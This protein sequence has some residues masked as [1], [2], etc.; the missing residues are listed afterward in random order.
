MNP[1]GSH[2]LSPQ[3]QSA[4]RRTKAPKLLSLR[5]I[6]NNRLGIGRIT[7]QTRAV[8]TIF[9]SWSGATRPLRIPSRSPSSA[10]SSPILLRYRKRST[11]DLAGSTIETS[12]PSM[13]C[14]LTPPATMRPLNRTK[15]TGDI[16]RWVSVRCGQRQHG[17]R[18]ASGESIRETEARMLGRKLP[19]VRGPMLPQGCVGS[20]GTRRKFGIGFAP[21][22][23]Q[24]GPE[25]AGQ[26]SQARRRRCKDRAC[27]PVRSDKRDTERCRA[28]QSVQV[29]F[30]LPEQKGA[31]VMSQPRGG[32]YCI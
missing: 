14:R 21:R 25:R 7:D 24:S 16:R 13:R 28:V 18:R 31:E 11:T 32:A 29:I 10:M 12:I 23:R 20:S 6:G 9:Q 15:R 4:K 5:A 19:W 2:C 1:N 17:H 22:A 27:G 26:Q 3:A 30:A 8:R